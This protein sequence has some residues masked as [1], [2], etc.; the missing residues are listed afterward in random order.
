MIVEGT[1]AAQTTSTDFLVV[2]LVDFTPWKIHAGFLA[3]V[4]ESYLEIVAL[5]EFATIEVSAHGCRG[6]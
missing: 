2:D 4:G 6:L 3:L 1:S 5:L